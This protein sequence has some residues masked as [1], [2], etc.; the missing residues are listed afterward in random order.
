MEYA[1][2]MNVNID[3]SEVSHGKE[4]HVSGNWRKGD[5]C[6]GVAG[7]L[8]ELCSRVLWKVELLNDEIGYLTKETSK[9]SVEVSSWFLPVLREKC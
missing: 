6:Y 5:P 4:E 2:N 8:A 1:R 9:Q 7:S 3:W